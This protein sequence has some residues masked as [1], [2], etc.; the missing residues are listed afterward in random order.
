MVPHIH[1]FH[2]NSEVFSGQVVVQLLLYPLM[3]L[4]YMW[5]SYLDR[6]DSPFL[7]AND[8][9]D[10]TD[11]IAKIKLTTKHTP[12]TCKICNWE[13]QLTT[14]LLV[15]NIPIRRQHI[16]NGH[17]LYKISAAMDRLLF[18]GVINAGRYY[19]YKAQRTLLSFNNFNINILLNRVPIIQNNPMIYKVH[20]Y[21][22]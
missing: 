9:C 17:K 19:L 10:R 4:V 13:K 7:I 1:I 5:W 16:W 11:Y 2:K 8:S 6:L 14:L 15:W 18:Q 21:I 22:H 12:G 3:S 20:M